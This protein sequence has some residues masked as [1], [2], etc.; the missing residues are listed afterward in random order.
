[1]NLVLL[2]KQSP[3]SLEKYAQFLIKNKKFDMA[4]EIYKKI[5]KNSE[6]FNHRF[7]LCL[8]MVQ[9]KRLKEVLQTLT[10]IIES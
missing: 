7:I 4:Y 6:D 10:S 9:R 5:N 3:S 2:N 1:M 8:F